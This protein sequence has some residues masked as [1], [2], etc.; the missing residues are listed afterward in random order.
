LIGCILAPQ[1]FARDLPVIE[2]DRAVG[3]DLII[4]V[5]FTRNHH[6][7]AALGLGNG[8]VNGLAAIGN[9]LNL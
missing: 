4:F 5:S 2:V 1:R 7:I 3:E 9:S 8:M 6:N